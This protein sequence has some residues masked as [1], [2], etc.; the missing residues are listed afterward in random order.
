LL[1]DRALQLLQ[2]PARFQTQLVAQ[3]PADLRIDRERVGLAP[4]AIQ[5]EHQL[6]TQPFLKRFCGDQRL[7]VRDQLIAI[8]DREVSVDPFHHRQHPELLEPADLRLDKFHPGDVRQRRAAPAPQR[9]PQPGRG[10]HRITSGQQPAPIAQH[11]FE[12]S[13]VKLL[14]RDAEHVPA[15]PCFQHR[16]LV[17]LLQQRPQPRDRDLHR[18]H[19]PHGLPLAEQL[20]D[21]RLDP[22]QLV[23]LDE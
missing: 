5:R 10:A 16:M 9:R 12:L 13:R 11:P 21:Q 22:H 8:A 3:Q 1:Q 4:D 15:R 23:R 20:L 2:S 18:V 14:R 7:K 19:R 17:A 6:A